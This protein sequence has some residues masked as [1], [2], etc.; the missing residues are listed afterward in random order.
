M[1]LF[2]AEVKKQQAAEAFIRLPT[3][4]ADKSKLEEDLPFMAI[5]AM[6]NGTHRVNFI[7]AHECATE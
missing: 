1:T 7:D 6:Q 2:T 5:E 4:D 3:T